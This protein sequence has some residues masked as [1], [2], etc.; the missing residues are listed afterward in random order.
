MVAF[1][2]TA[3]QR[4]ELDAARD[5]VVK[6]PGRLARHDAREPLAA[7][8]LRGAHNVPE[9]L[10]RRVV[11]VRQAGRGLEAADRGHAIGRGAAAAEE[12]LQRQHHAGAG[13]RG[14]QRGARARA[15]A[16]DDQHVRVDDRNHSRLRVTPS[17]A[18]A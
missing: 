2:R 10:L 9:V 17:V 15:P 4:V 5:Q 11:G 13:L 14:A 1:A 8:P 3:V 16:S 12:A 7:H 18:E 6:D